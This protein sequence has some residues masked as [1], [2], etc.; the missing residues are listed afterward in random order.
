MVIEAIHPSGERNIQAVQD[1][2]AEVFASS[3]T[4]PILSVKLLLSFALVLA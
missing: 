4:A 3:H 2:A 1:T